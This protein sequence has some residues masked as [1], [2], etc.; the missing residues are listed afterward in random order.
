MPG[1][2]PGIHGFLFWLGRLL[3]P[4]ASLTRA[5]GWNSRPPNL[6]LTKT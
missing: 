5:T 4:A 3:G 1:P 2:V 6:V